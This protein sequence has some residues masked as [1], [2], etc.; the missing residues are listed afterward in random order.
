MGM[1][2]RADIESYTRQATVMNLGDLHQQGQTVIRIANEQA[3]KIL[4]DARA[5]RQRLIE[6][7]AKEGREQGYKDGQRE[8]FEAGRK[9]GFTQ[10]IVQHREQ[11]DTLTSEWGEALGVFTAARDAMY[12]NARRDVV[13]LAVRIAQ[14]IT[15]RVI[16]HDAGAVRTQ[17]ESVLDTLARPT[18]LV[19]RVNPE[20]LAYAETVLPGLIA[21]CMNCA[22]AEVVGDPAVSQ[23]SCFA[24]TE[25]GGVIDASIETQLARIVEEL[26]PGEPRSDS[27]IERKDDAA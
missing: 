26:I 8:G 18:G 7:A 10:A 3:E 15:R 20:D 14:R 6:G 13:E 19:L 2:R 25:G 4:R 27:D 11:I 16:K 5:E 24:E 1:I 17:M 21:D 9:E 22:H 23:G 12:Q